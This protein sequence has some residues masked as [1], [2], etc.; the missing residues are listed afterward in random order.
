[1]KYEFNLP[2]SVE[3]IIKRINDIVYIYPENSDS[4]SLTLYK[5]DYINNI[6]MQ[7]FQK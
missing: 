1:M 3:F 4:N 7:T 6:I 5:Y 2:N